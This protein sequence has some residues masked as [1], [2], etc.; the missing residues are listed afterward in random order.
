MSVM[1]DEKQSQKTSAEAVGSLYK[2]DKS[3]RCRH[4]LLVEDSPVTQDLIA[5]LL[6]RMGIKLSIAENGQ[7]AIDV[8]AKQA[9]DLVL[10][11]CQ[12]PKLDGFETTAYIRSQGLKTTIVALTAYSQV[13]DEQKCL[14]AGMDDFL[15]KPFRQSELKNVLTRWMGADA[16]KGAPVI[17]ASNR[18]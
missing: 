18:D 14:D 3:R 16:L 1:S 6:E 12:M 10:M 7:E 4:V 15:C 2:R 13:E 8:L 11:D 5:I 17:E 9:F